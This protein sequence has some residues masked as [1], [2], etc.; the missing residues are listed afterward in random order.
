MEEGY[1]VGI[2][3]KEKLQRSGGP[4]NAVMKTANQSSC[5]L[6]R[7]LALLSQCPVLM[8]Y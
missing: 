7:E 2:V 4:Y 6:S 8:S 3:S 1:C 5:A